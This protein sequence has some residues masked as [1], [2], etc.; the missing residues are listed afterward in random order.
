M[1]TQWPTLDLPK[2]LSPQKM[3]HFPASL[4]IIIWY[5]LLAIEISKNK[6]KEGSVRI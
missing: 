4:R 3:F 5:S 6:G 2:L 1:A